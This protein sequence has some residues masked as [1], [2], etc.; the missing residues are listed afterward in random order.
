M[1]GLHGWKD[2][3]QSLF[4]HCNF[5][6]ARFQQPFSTE[7]L[8]ASGESFRKSDNHWQRLSNSSTSKRGGI[9]TGIIPD[10]N[11]NMSESRINPKEQ[12][13]KTIAAM[14]LVTTKRT[15]WFCKETKVHMI[16]YTDK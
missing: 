4:Y 3:N 11:K 10:Q 12:K 14:S 2:Q 6:M 16:V 5:F 13:N 1:T 9:Q 7:S 15:M 8:D